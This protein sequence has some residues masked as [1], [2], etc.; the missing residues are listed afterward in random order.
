KSDAGGK[1]VGRLARWDA[2]DDVRHVD[3]QLRV[4]GRGRVNVFLGRAIVAR[5]EERPEVYKFNASLRQPEYIVRLEVNDD[6]AMLVEP[7]EDGEPF[8]NGF[9]E[10]SDPRLWKAFIGGIVAPGLQVLAMEK[11]HRDVGELAFR[12]KIRPIVKWHESPQ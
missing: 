8:V 2:G 7:R 4:I 1:D 5:G 12:H 11:L 6:H 9:L 3:E 10:L